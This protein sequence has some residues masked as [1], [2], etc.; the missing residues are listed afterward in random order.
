MNH[1]T[2]GSTLAV[3]LAL[4][5]L[6]T[7]APANAGTP[8]MGHGHPGHGEPMMHMLS[9]LNLS[10]DQKTQVHAVFED[11][12]SRMAPL[13]EGSMKAH[14]ALEQAIHAPTFDESAIRAAAAQAGAAEGELSVEKGRMLSRIR[15]LLTPDQQKQMEALH[16]QM[17]QRHGRWGDAP[18]DPSD[19]E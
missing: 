8:P 6:L 2:K 4:A 18:D 13:K 3:G 1:G 15:A 11:E 9:Q 17:S 12:H 19:P 14:H 10:D 16:E 7:V 5:G